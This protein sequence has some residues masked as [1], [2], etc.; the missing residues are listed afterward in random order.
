MENIE[1]REDPGMAMPQY[2][3]PTRARYTYDFPKTITRVSGI[4]KITVVELTAQEELMATKRCNNDPIRLAYEMGLQCLVAIDGK[5][6]S[7]V[8]GTADKAWETMH[9]QARQLV[10]RAYN[11]LHNVQQNDVTDFLKSRSTEVG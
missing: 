5:E 2:E 4:K 8:D 1:A 6:V 9:P 10:M 11:E 3:R 7:L